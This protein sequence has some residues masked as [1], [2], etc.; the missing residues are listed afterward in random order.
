MLIS[1][2]RALLRDLESILINTK[3]EAAKLTAA[4]LIM[5]NV[6]L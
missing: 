1:Q 5:R 3:K 2:K 6:Q 4:S